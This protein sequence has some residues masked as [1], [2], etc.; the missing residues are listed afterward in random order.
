[1]SDILDQNLGKHLIKREEEMNGVGRFIVNFT[2][3]LSDT[4]AEVF[5]VSSILLN[6]AKIGLFWQYC[7]YYWTFIWPDLK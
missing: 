5:S 2:S 1:M 3:D 4:F 6:S 7:Q